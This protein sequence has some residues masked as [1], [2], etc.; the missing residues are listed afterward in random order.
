MMICKTCKTQY[1]DDTLKYCLQ[2]GTVLTSVPAAEPPTIAFGETETV[3]PGRGWEETRV[4]RIPER[5]PESKRSNTVIAILLTVLAMLVIFGVVA[6]IYLKGEPGN[7]AKNVN[8]SPDTNR[9]SNVRN[10][11]TAP[12]PV[13]TNTAPVNMAVPPVNTDEVKRDVIKTIM[14]WKA[15]GESRDLESYMG[16]YAGTVD[17]YL[18][19]GVSRSF[20]RED[21]RRHFED[22][23][24]IRSD[25]T[26]ID[27]TLSPA[28]DVATA[29]FD[30]E[31]D[32]EGV[33][34]ST[35]KVRQQLRLRNVNGNWLI[36]GERDLHVY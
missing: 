7:I 1:V 33:R 32:F 23:T 2:D 11:P 10:T 5:P 34:H 16:N 29:L 4:T 30:K 14:T 28:G 26:N 25:I 12:V 13:S 19:K 15:M 6:W 17:Y 35:G 22:Y 3:V 20:V 36:T 9:N 8:S 24:S 18:K 21:K 31:W 27:I